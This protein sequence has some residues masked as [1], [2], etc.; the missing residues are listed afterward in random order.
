MTNE[1][2]KALAR[3]VQEL[4]VASGPAWDMF[5]QALTLHLDEVTENCIHAPPEHLAERQGR[6]RE[7]RDLF[8]TLVNSPQLAAQMAE[9]ERR[10]AHPHR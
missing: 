2:Q 6:A 3:A 9:K 1:V 4:R 7:I 10:D 5:L 8:K